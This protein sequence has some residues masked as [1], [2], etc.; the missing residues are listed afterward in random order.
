M[1]ILPPVCVSAGT[2]WPSS[3]KI[4]V[5]TPETQSPLA[6]PEFAELELVQPKRSD[7]STVELVETATEN[8]EFK[9]PRVLRV[10][11]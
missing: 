3:T 8:V 10:P 5:T 4:P 1:V 2:V 9:V 7:S 6:L 11:A